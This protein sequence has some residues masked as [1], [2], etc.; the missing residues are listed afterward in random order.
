MEVN[1]CTHVE[2]SRIFIFGLVLL[3]STMRFMDYLRVLVIGMPSIWGLHGVS[4]DK[5]PS[6][7]VHEELMAMKP[8]TRS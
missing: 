2:S 6:Y 4:W 7:S 5:P 8:G 3:Y 1:I